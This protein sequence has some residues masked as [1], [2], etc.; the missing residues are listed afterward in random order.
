MVQ[1]IRLDY[2][3]ATDELAWVGDE[4]GDAHAKRVLARRGTFR[5]TLHFCE[6][7]NPADYAGRK[8]VAAEARR[9]IEQL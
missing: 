1:P 4:S 8:A 2:G 9:R 3:D 7:F 5:P 6:P